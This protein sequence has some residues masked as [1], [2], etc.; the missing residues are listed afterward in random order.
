MVIFDDM[1]V[2]ILSNKKLNPIVTKLFFRGKKLN[3]TLVFITQSYFSVS[4]YNTLNS[5]HFVIMEIPNKR[6]LPNKLQI[7]VN[8]SSDTDFKYYTDL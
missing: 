8:H 4:K 1:I 5:T 7:A 2:D 3:I 6:E